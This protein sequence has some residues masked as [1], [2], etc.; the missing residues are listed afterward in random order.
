MSRFFIF[1][2][3]SSVRSSLQASLMRLLPSS[4]TNER[5]IAAPTP[6]PKPSA[7]KEDD[8][9]W[10]DTGLTNAL[11]AGSTY[12]RIPKPEETKAAGANSLFDGGDDFGGYDSP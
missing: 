9:V 12:S 11:N 2:L 8:S 6:T 4:L 3:L 10:E 7:L 1:P 5:F